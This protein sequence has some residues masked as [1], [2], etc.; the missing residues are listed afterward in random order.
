VFDRSENRFNEDGAVTDRTDAAAQPGDPE[1][2]LDTAGR[3]R[4]GRAADSI[5]QCRKACLIIRAHTALQLQK[6]VLRHDLTIVKLHRN[7]IIAM[8]YFGS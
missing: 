3:V 1:V 8:Q 2:D 4:R 6:A 7:I 5:P